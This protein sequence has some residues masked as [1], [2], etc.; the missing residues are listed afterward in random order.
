MNAVALED[1]CHPLAQSPLRP[2]R[3]D[4]APAWFRVQHGPAAVDARMFRQA[5]ASH[6]A[7]LLPTV[8]CHVHFAGVASDV[9][10]VARITFSVVHV[11]FKE[12]QP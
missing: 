9:V 12:N 1:I 5:A 11:Q 4:T 3:S 8:P 6:G 10:E 2:G 7:R